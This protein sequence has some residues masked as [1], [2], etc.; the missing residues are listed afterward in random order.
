MNKYMDDTPISVTPR[1]H[2]ILKKRGMTQRNW[3]KSRACPRELSADL[4]KA[5]STLTGIFLR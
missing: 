4:I 3:R 5:A 1:L 2:E